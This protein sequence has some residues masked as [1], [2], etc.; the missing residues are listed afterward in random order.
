MKKV[1][2]SLM[3]VL[4]AAFLFTSC[5][6]KTEILQKAVEKV[7]KDGGIPK[8]D[9]GV[10]FKDVVF[11]PS[12]NTISY[13]IEIPAQMWEPVKFAAD[14]PVYKDFFLYSNKDNEAYKL[15]A[16]LLISVNGTLQFTYECAGG[17]GAPYSLTFGSDA[18][19][20][21]VD[22][23]LP[24]V[25]PS[26]LKPYQPEAPQAVP[27]EDGYGDPCSLY[28]CLVYELLP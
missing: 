12:S 2:L 26:Q 14:Q 22:G 8:T 25:D 24:A 20:K 19:K 13:I 11:E 4:T 23:T 21:L 27:A 3:V 17:C 6:S 5:A 9:G 18:L 1:F 28:P 10:L 7:K 16:D 15:L